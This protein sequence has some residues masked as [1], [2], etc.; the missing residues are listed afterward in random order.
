VLKLRSFL[1]HEDGLSDVSLVSEKTPFSLEA[2]DERAP[3][4]F[5]DVHVLR[6]SLGALPLVGVESLLLA[7]ELLRLLGGPFG[8]AIL[9][10]SVGHLDATGSLGES[11]GVF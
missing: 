8:R 10:S 7:I 3:V 4:E 11:G 1:H 2:L 5:D 9:F 6:A